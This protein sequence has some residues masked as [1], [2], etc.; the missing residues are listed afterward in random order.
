M[1]FQY[2]TDYHGEIIYTE[3]F[4]ENQAFFKYDEQEV[5][6]RG[7]DSLLRL[8]ISYLART[9]FSPTSQRLSK[10]DYIYN[11]NNAKWIKFAYGLLARNF[12]RLTNKS[13]YQADSV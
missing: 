2:A 11:G 12:H 8:G 5:A 6:Y 1:I 7:I 4:K 10:G 13:I 9:D 3:A